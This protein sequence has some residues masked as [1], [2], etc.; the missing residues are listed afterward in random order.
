MFTG[1][2]TPSVESVAAQ[3]DT[4]TMSKRVW[5]TS[6]GLVGAVL[7][8]GAVTVLGW[9]I[10][11]THFDRPDEGFDRMATEL[12]SLPGVTVDGK[13]RW[14]EAPTF[15]DPTSWI[16]ITVDEAGLP[17]LLDAACDR[18][19]P[20]AVTWSLSV[21]TDRENVVTFHNDST[22]GEFANNER[23]TDFGFDAVGFVGGVDSATAGLAVQGTIWDDDQFVLVAPEDRINNLA[24]LLPLVAS[25]ND[26]RD[27][28]GLAPDR[29]VE[30]NG[31]SL[32]LI[33]EPT[34]HDRYFAMLSTL[35]N[36]H[37]VTSFWAD[38]GGT[39][40]DGVE[41]VQIVAPEGEHTAIED[42]I[43]ASDLHIA[44]FPVRFIPQTD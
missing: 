21:E 11:E 42:A 27:A 19:Y 14:V 6:I 4:R 35:V 28:A 12:E 24:A 34:E 36:E 25:S 23:C 17:G 7:L 40:T 1:C 22:S 15:V 13:E 38:G 37:G 41:K 2:H 39:P 31:A 43:R 33:V 5:L 8:V 18:T 44:D 16:G 26:L 3:V 30:I 10:N 29:S 20:D 9:T 32:S